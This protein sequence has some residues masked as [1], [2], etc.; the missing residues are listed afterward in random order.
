MNGVSGA[1]RESEP[2][3]Y[4]QIH[5]FAFPAL[6][7]ILSYERKNSPQ[8]S[9]GSLVLTSKDPVRIAPKTLGIENNAK[10]AGAS[11]QTVRHLGIP[12]ES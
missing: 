9:S 10:A 3:S 1:K 12:N 8:N 2:V 11:P 5:P 7:A 4:S 6:K